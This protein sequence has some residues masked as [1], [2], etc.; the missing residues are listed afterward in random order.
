MKHRA[1]PTGRVH[2]TSG[3]H[4]LTASHDHPIACS[5]YL[6]S[7][8]CRI[9]ADSTFLFVVIRLLHPDSFPP[10][11]WFSFFIS[12][13]MTVSFQEAIFGTVSMATLH[14]GAVLESANSLKEPH[15]H[16]R[17]YTHRDT[18]INVYTYREMQRGKQLNKFICNCMKV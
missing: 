12:K 16:A 17:T 2:D 1:E 3:L 8:A 18:H 10:D 7:P 5:H 14:R 11:P 9:L 6:W 13:R 15:T 4:W